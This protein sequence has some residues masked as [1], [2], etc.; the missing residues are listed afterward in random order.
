MALLRIHHYGDPILLEQGTPFEAVDD[1]VRV[2]AGDMIET[3][4]AEKGVGL[5]AQ[6]VG[7][8]R[9]ICVVEVPAGLDEDE[10][11]TPLN[12]DLAMPL[13]L[14][15]PEVLSFTRKTTCLEEGCLSFP[16]IT[17]NIRRPYGIRLRYTDLD[18][19]E[20]EIDVQ[21][22]SARVIQHEIDHLNGVLF[23]RHMSPA[24][25]VALKG[26]LR[27]LAEETRETLGLA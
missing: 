17:G 9:R 1:E 8:T 11:G 13:A 24:K 14:V 19:V 4:R 15:N 16:G 21:G 2:L 6:Q 7:L 26:R 20:R 18:G 27:R 5:A 22:F 25:R 10:D 3:M 23:T 12:P